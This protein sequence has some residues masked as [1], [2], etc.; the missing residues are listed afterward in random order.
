[1][2]ILVFLSSLLIFDTCADKMNPKTPDEAGSPVKAKPKGFL[3]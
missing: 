3:A 2:K 1:M